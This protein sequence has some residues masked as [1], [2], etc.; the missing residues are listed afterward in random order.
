VFTTD[1]LNARFRLDVADPLEGVDDTEADSESLWKEHEI[2]D[3]MTEAADAVARDTRG[4]Y[5]LLELPVSAGESKVVLPRSVLELRLARLVGQN[6][7]VF[8]ANQNDIAYGARVCD[9]GEWLPLSGFNAT[10]TPRMYARDRVKKALVLSPVPTQDD[11]LECQCVVTLATPLL[12][13][14]PLP[15]LERP[16]IRLMLH[17]MKYLAYAKQDADTLDLARSESFKSRYDAEATEREVTL[18]RQRR[19]PSPI[20]MEGW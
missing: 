10:G 3:Y 14:M 6:R 12:C 8:D 4:L 18:R 11:T 17:F 7:I 9:Y 15:F 2:Y 19:M 20:R 16:D 5:K 13:G 1:E